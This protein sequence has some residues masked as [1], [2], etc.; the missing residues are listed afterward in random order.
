MLVHAL[1]CA[2]NGQELGGTGASGAAAVVAEASFE[3]PADC[4]AQWLRLRNAARVP[5]LQTLSGNVVVSGV[6][7]VPD[8]TPAPSAPG[9]AAVAATAA[10][11]VN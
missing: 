9:G 5:A 11:V 1:H 4:G 3:V 2:G 8:P 7:I 6:A 10:G